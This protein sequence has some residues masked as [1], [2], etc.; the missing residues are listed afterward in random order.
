MTTE[1]ATAPKDGITAMEVRRAGTVTIEDLMPVLDLQ[2]A[3]RRRAFIIE[4]TKNLM[5][6]GVDY[7]T[8]PGTGS[9]P[10]LLKPGAERLCTLFGMSPEV[11]ELMVVED[12]T[13][14]AH[15]GEQFYYY[16]YKVRLVKNGITLGEGVGSCNSWEAK[17]RY[18]TQERKCPK[19]GKPS[20]VKGREEY[21]GGWICFTKKGGCGAKFKAGDSAIEGQA[22]GRTLNPDMADLVNTLQKMAVKRALIAATLIAV[23]ASE[24]YTQDAEDMEVI[25]VPS[26]EPP[27]EAK[28]KPSDREADPPSARQAKPQPNQE[29]PARPW[30]T[31]KGMLDEFARLRSRLK[32]DYEHIYY[33]TL[34]EFHVAHSNEFKNGD[35][36]AACYHQ[37]LPKVLQVEAAARG[38]EAELPAEGFDQPPEASA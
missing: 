27:R 18:R 26:A 7:G 19:C 32:P 2:S 20:I 9:K 37:L 28:A 10:T 8:I 14:E 34:R 11:H 5:V 16:R 13:G 31:F 1:I 38:A 29:A 24:F 15:G 21:G 25:D 33:E 17:Y 12:W 6:E 3:M 35:Q 23:N 22:T 30:R 4:V 36:A